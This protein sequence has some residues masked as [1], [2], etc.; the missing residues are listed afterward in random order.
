M[1]LYRYFTLNHGLEA[2]QTGRWKIGRLTELNDPLDSTP[3][4]FSSESTLDGQLNLAEVREEF[5]K[6]IS[7]VTALLCFSSNINEPVIWSHYAEAHNGIALGFDFS[8][9]DYPPLEVIYSENRPRLDVFDFVKFL[10]SVNA[11]KMH[12]QFGDKLMLAFRTK[13]PGWS[14][15]REFRAFIDLKK[16]F[17]VGSHYFNAMPAKP[18]RQV[19]LGER[20]PFSV[21]DMKRILKKGPNSNGADFDSYEH[22]EVK[23]CAADP[24]RFTLKIE[25]C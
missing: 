25:D 23:K 2:L 1:I 18:L 21:I 24:S 12:T 3:H 9:E 16:C 7:S 8:E 6:N 11:E 22:V 10:E 4:L 5:L 13:A 19:I 20:C 14:Y 17:L 15:E